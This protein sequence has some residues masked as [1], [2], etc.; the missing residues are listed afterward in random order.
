[1]ISVVNNCTQ[2][3]E[4]KAAPWSHEKEGIKKVSLFMHKLNA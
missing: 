2:R 3:W 4:P 1:M